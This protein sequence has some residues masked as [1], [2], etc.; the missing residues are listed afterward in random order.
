VIHVFGA[1]RARLSLIVG[2]IVPA[3]VL[4]ATV[5]G[6]PLARAAADNA[7]LP[8]V[9]HDAS[10][11]S[12][13]CPNPLLPGFPL[14]LGPEFRCGY[15]TVPENRHRLN[16]RTIQV[17]VAIAPA[18][19]RHPKADPLLWLEGGPGGSGL[20]VANTIV[21][22]GI[23]ADR[24]VIFVDQRGTP[25]ALPRLGCPT[26]D[27]FLNR[28]FAL[29]PTS[30]TA[31]RQAVASLA[32][33]R[34]TWNSR[35]Y[36]LGSFNTPENA[37]D[38]ADLRLA[39]GIKTWNV[40]GVSYGT[41]VALQLLRDYPGG[42]RSEA[43]DSVVPPQVNLTTDFWSNAAAGFA[44]VFRACEAR[45]ACHAAYPHLAADLLTAVDRLTR[46]PVTVRVLDPA[47][48]LPTKVVFDGFQFAN[49]LV[50]LSLTPGSI[51][52]M[53]AYV[54]EMASGD[55]AQAAQRLLATA[56]PVVGVAGDGLAFT[57]FCS[58]NA[59]FTTPAKALAA[60]RR[61]LPAFPAQVLALTPQI[62][63]LFADCRAWRVG[64]APAGARAPAHS[65]IPVLEM[66]GTFD[67]VTSL[68]WAKTAA[69]TLPRA[70]IIRFPGLGHG[71]VTW[72][73]CGAQVLVGFLNRPGGGYSTRCVAKL[74]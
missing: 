41:D 13:P 60:A 38:M 33:C 45:A 68:A 35:G 39:L 11:R 25:K 64:R 72:S 42:I 22:Q 5:L 71:V 6:P 20:G 53:P 1:L 14:A 47:S 37:A 16:G 57:V 48:H 29:A 18:V 46:R 43:L 54:H 56:S 34:R 55:A 30:A 26:Y 40:Y 23:N 67:A 63:H 66:S 7:R 2:A 10:Y 49:L 17:A 44:A 32:A 61:A 52:P 70:R 73:Q 36:D 15:L 28:S 50:V 58:E 3:A 65:R 21:A 8:G 31:R 12:A 9:G 74:P 62:A 59:A 19:S 51:L 69:A 27:T 24:D 4:M